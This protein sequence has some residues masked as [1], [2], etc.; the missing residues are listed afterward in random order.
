MEIALSSFAAAVTQLQQA[1]CNVIVDDITYFEGE[2]F[3]QDAGV[4]DTAIGNAIADGVSYF[5]AAGNF[6]GQPVRGR[7]Q[8]ARLHLP[9]RLGVWRLLPMAVITKR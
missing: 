8:S 6:G 3:F 9:Q 5:T 1:G 2:P 7:L 4:I